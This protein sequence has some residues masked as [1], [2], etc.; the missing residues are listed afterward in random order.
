MVVETVQW[1]SR[2]VPKSAMGPMNSNKN[3]LNS[4][5]S[6]PFKLMPNTT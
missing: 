3:K 4:K 1:D 6:W 5:K 2:I